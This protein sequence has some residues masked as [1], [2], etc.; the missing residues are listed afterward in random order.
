MVM[1]KR[2]ND[3]S[4]KAAQVTHGMKVAINA[5]LTANGHGPAVIT[6]GQRQ[7]RPG[8][9]S[10]HPVPY[11]GDDYRCNNLPKKIIKGMLGIFAAFKLADSN[12]G[13]IRHGKG[14]KDHIHTQY[15]KGDPI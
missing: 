7:P 14:A 4:A 13:Y 5:Y 2:S 10:Y 15:R 11:Q 8:K 1:Y 6:C 3:Y 12:V 9:P